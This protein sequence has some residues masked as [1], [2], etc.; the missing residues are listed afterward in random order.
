MNLSKWSI[1]LLLFLT[2]LS[3]QSQEKIP[4]GQ[5]YKRAAENLD[6]NPVIVIHGMG[7]AQ[8]NEKGTHRVAWGA[9]TSQS[10]DPSVREGM[11]ALTLPL[12]SSDLWEQEDELYACCPLENF[13]VEL[14][15][16]RF[17]VHIYQKILQTLGVGKYKI[18][19]HPG[20]PSYTKGC[21][22]FTFFYD[23]RQD[24]VANAIRF[25]KFLEERAKVAQKQYKL[26]GIEKKQVRF[27]IVAHSM[28]GLIARYYLRYGTRDV[29]SQKDAPVTWAGSKRIARLFLVGTP[30][31]GSIDALR[32][33]LLGEEF[34]PFLPKIEPAILFTFPSVYQLLPPAEKKIFLDKK[35]DEVPLDLYQAATWEE[36]SWGI[37]REDQRVFL[38]FLLGKNYLVKAKAHLQRVLA[39]ARAFQ[40]A[41]NRS[42]GSLPPSEIYLFASNTIPTLSRAR[43]EF[44]RDQFHLSFQGDDL[45]EP[46]DGTVPFSSAL[47][48]QRAF[49]ESPARSHG[50]I[51]FRAVHLFHGA[52]RNMVESYTF[53]NNLLYLLLETR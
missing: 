18:A 21:S 24:N 48:D 36:N 4:L 8:L 10:V 5:I 53:Q 23:W 11:R 16:L 45:M 1:P 25:G 17:S 27:D 37:F 12:S 41:L 20:V 30:N 51:P 22:C 46:G 26:A 49:R 14:G 29:L 9:F 28:G 42:P 31:G 39:R 3:C 43:A 35:G 7:G 19:L 34:G 15:G 50:H 40:K 44:R 33:L 47:G 38:Q 6:R 52:H 2:A 13:E 32:A